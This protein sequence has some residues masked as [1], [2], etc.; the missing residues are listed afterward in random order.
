MTPSTLRVLTSI[1]AYL[2][3]DLPLV[4]AGSQLPRCV[5]ARGIAMYVIRQHYRPRPT[6]A[7]IGIDFD[8]HHTSVV[9]ALARIEMR[10]HD[11]MALGAIEVGRDALG[12]SRAQWVTKAKERALEEARAR[13]A[14]LEAELMGATGT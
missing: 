4:R 3:V 10:L 9:A 7:E 6:L 12:R 5:L 14:E 8:R 2:S 13:V 11:E 1:C